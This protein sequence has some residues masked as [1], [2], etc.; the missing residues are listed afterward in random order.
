MKTFT[1]NLIAAVAVGFAALGMAGPANAAPGQ[2]PMGDDA[3]KMVTA[4]MNE[5]MHGATPGIPRAV[6]NDRGVMFYCDR[7]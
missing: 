4:M 2:D 1:T 7:G 3:M 5:C 6:Q